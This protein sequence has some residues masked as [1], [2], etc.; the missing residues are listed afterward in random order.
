MEQIGYHQK[1]HEP[2]DLFLR[3]AKIG[4]ELTNKLDN[5]GTYEIGMFLK[6]ITQFEYEELI[7]TLHFIVKKFE[8]NIDA[9]LDKLQHIKI[10]EYFLTNALSKNQYHI[11]EKKFHHMEDLKNKKNISEIDATFI[12][13]KTTKFYCLIGFIYPFY[14]EFKYDVNTYPNEWF[15]KTFVK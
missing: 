4:L 7:Q 5:W 10:P 8:K 6:Y 12:P 15:N 9:F 11:D 2:F 14:F 3:C 1:N 13:E